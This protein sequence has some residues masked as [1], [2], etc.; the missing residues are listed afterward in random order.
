MNN[1]NISNPKQEVSSGMIMN[2]KDYITDIL[3]SLKC[4]VK[5]YAVALTEASNDALHS[6][7]LNMFSNFDSLQ[8]EVYQLMFTKGWYVIEKAD[9]DKITQKYNL[10]N[11]ELTNLNNN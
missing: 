3:S 10:L 7:Y 5:D 6:K 4:L 1:N 9:D 8:R 2:D 11:E